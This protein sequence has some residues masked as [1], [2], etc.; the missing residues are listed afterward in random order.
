[1]NQRIALIPAGGVGAR[2]GLGYPKQ[3]LPL[4]G[5][6]TLLEAT[7]QALMGCELFDR[8]VVVTAPEDAYIDAIDLAEGVSVL[9]KGGATRAHTVLNGLR[10]LKAQ[11]EDWIY[12][13][14]A[15]RPC[16]AAEDVRALAQTVEKGDVD[17]AILAAV[18]TDT[19]KRVNEAGIIQATA[20][21]NAIWRA[22]TPQVSRYATL[23]AA[24]ETADL[25][26]ITDEAS[27]LEAAGKTCCVLQGRSDNIKVTRAEDIAQ[28]RHYLQGS[29]MQI[30][31][32]QGY[33]IHRLVPGRELILGGVKI[34]YELGLDG[35]SDADVLLHAITDALL[36]AAALGDI[37]RHFP[38]TDPAYKGADSRVLLQQAYQLVQQAGYR[39]M[40][41][42]ASIIAQA[43][44]LAPVME[45][46][47]ASVASVLGVDVGQ[48]N[49]KAKTNEKLDAVGQKQGIAAQ[50]VV[51]IEKV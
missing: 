39:L 33:D 21:R 30:R 40:N 16:V 26:K 12:V 11:A 23:L 49:I 19:L 14:D 51:L 4:L 31:V 10:A 32:G 38:D 27:A 9:K 13:H 47:N 35:H 5:Q 48:V 41:L 43:P 46:I 15:A 44:K 3:Y 50:C 8:I 18:S 34:N 36:G 25:D 6:T 7:V 17:G 2:L 42:D 1:M 22:M 29:M 45:Q 24:L 37:G 20:D 28:A